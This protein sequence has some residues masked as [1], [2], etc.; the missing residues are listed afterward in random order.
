MPSC[1]ADMSPNDIIRSIGGAIWRRAEGLRAVHDRGITER[2]ST[3]GGTRY[4]EVETPVG[5][6]VEAY[7]PTEGAHRSPFLSEHFIKSRQDL[8]T[9]RYVVEATHYE[10]WYEPTLEALRAVGDDGVV[11]N[12]CFSV[13]FIQFAKMDAGY[14]AAFLLQVDYPDEVALLTSAYRRLF[15]EGY[16]VLAKGPADI[17]ATGDNM[18]ELTMPPR[19][20]EREALPFYRDA[21]KVVHAGGKLF[22]AHWC[23]RTPHLL[24]YLPDSG[25]DIVEAVVTRPMAP[26]TL[27]DAIDRLR[28]DVTLQG[29][30]PSVLVCREG[31]DDREFDNYITGTV[32]PLTGRSGFV[33]G[34]SD[35]VPPNADFDR[36]ARVAQLLQEASDAQ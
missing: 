22:E 2:W 35:N 10:P 24:G 18:D 34:M 28:G 29:G 7:L 1:F 36:V 32:A 16:E 3:C 17:V 14:Q 30:I 20:F 6:L 4:H 13:P 27:A 8:R 33:V 19:L 9:M 25:L 5:S 31:C 11:L 12:S 21:A 26:I 23:G 15:L